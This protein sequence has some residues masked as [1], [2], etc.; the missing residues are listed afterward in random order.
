M[1]AQVCRAGL[2]RGVLV[3]YIIFAPVGVL[4]PE[5]PR[6]VFDQRELAPTLTYLKSVST[7]LQHSIST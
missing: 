1:L 6:L 4:Y 7:F 5:C 2:Q 3:Q